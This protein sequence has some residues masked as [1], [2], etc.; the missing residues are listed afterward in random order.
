MTSTPSRASSQAGA[1]ADDAGPDDCDARF[2][3]GRGTGRG[4]RPPRRFAGERLALVVVTPL[5][6]LASEGK[7]G[8]RLHGEPRG[9]EKGRIG[10]LAAGR[11]AP[12][13]DPRPAVPSLAAAH[14]GPREA[15]ERPRLVGAGRDARAKRPRRDRL[16]AAHRHLV[17]GEAG[18]VARR[19]EE[20]PER[21][22]KAA[23]AGARPK[24]P[25]RDRLELRRK[26]AAEAAGGGEPGEGSLGEGRVRSAHRAP[27]A[28]HE[29]P[30]KRGLAPVVPDDGEAS[31]PGVEAMLA[32]EQPGELGRG[33]E[34]VA[35]AHRV[36][37]EHALAS[38]N[39]IASRVDA[40]E[41][42][43]LHVFVTPLDPHEDVPVEHRDAAAYE[44]R[45]VPE[46][47]SDELGR[48]AKR[49]ECRPRPGGRRGGGF[50]N[51]RHLDAS[52]GELARHLE[53]E[54][55]IAGDEHPFPR[56]DPVGAGEGLGRPGGHDPG[57]GP[58]GNRMRPLV[59]PGGND[60][61]ARADAARAPVREDFDLRRQGRRARRS[62]CLV[63]ART[64]A[65]HR[66]RAHDLHPRGPDPVDE[67]GP[68]SELPVAR[69]KPG[70]SVARGELLEVLPARL[71]PLVEDG[72]EHAGPGGGLG[73]GEAGRTGPD[74]D[75]VPVRF[76]APARRGRQRRRDEG[77]R[78]R[79]G[80]GRFVVAV[81]GD[82][83][84]VARV[85]HARPLRRKAVH[86]HEALEAD[87]HA[88]ED[89]ARIAAARTAKRGDARRGEGG[90]QRLALDRRHR[91][92]LE[93]DRDGR[94]AGDDAAGTQA[95]VV[96]MEAAHRILL[97]RRSTG[98]SERRSSHA[99]GPLAA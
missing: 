19:R 45:E 66:G 15:L 33:M 65:P 21:V 77:G 13:G 1:D 49:G 31:R 76:G 61:L 89:A 25:P 5:R 71:R 87:P 82:R 83:H 34:A 56:R 10:R 85:G 48:T 20:R 72:R 58:A 63:P 2:G 50:R 57:E 32:A 8:Y 93:L 36:H 55:P 79:S 38:R 42:R 73:R 97:V 91:P 92:P 6:H 59:S 52:R 74:D 64:G 3:N 96:R 60:E 67:A 78:L 90:G 62:A 17:A 44:G 46:A 54:R 23:G 27:V 7:G 16:A 43:S 18:E 40:G 28:G 24:R 69:S 94:S 80:A 88:A 9:E 22:L 47:P 30:G 70:E 98:P 81:C 53:V 84:A 95:K 99:R 37:I 11:R 29:Y 4:G 12:R 41:N 39:D 75:E 51:R 68:G 86:R 14:A 35:H 26:R